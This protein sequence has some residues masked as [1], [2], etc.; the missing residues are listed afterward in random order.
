MVE[1]LLK[2]GANIELWDAFG[3]PALHYA[4]LARKGLPIVKMLVEHGANVNVVNVD[5]QTPLFYAVDGG[6]LREYKFRIPGA[7]SVN[8]NTIKYLIEHGANANHVPQDSWPILHILVAKA[9]FDILS[10]ILEIPNFDVDLRNHNGRT[11]LHSATDALY[12][13]TECAVVLLKHNA[14]PNIADQK[15]NTPLISTTRGGRSSHINLLMKYGADPSLKNNEGKTAMDY[16]VEISELTAVPAQTIMRQVYV[17]RTWIFER[18][19]FEALPRELRIRIGVV[20]KLWLVARNEENGVLSG[21]PLEVLYA[22]LK[23]MLFE[24][25]R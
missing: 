17:N 21:V 16:A 11:P 22:L 3:T 12:D 18:E 2:F 6:L 20:V 25:L 4:S 13:R 23:E 7:P 9:R 8:W 14:N 15:G 19:Q 1:L 10:E 24:Q 5:D